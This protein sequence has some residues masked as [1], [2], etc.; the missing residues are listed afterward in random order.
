VSLPTPS[1]QELSGNISDQIGASLEQTV[2]ILPKAFI[3]VLAKVLAGLVVILWK[4]CGFIFLQLFVAYATDKETTING[5]IVR[6]LVELGRRSGI[7]DPEPAI[8]AQHKISVTVTVQ[9]GKLASGTALLF[10]AANIIYETV[11][12]VA[13]DASTVT[14]N[15]RAVSDQSGGDGSGSIGNRQNGDVL[16]FANPPPNVVSKATVVG[17]EVAGTD[18]ETTDA[19]RARLLTKTQGKPQGGCYADYVDWALEVPGI[20]NVY[21]YASP[22]PGEVDIYVEADQASSGSADGIATPAQITAVFNA[23]QFIDSSGL[24]SRRP[25]GA[26]I[27]V[28]PITRTAVLVTVAGFDPDVQATREALKAGVDEFLRTREPYIEGLS[29]L[30]RRDRVTDSAIGGVVQTIVD[31]NGASVTKVTASPGPAFTLGPGQKAKLDHINY[32]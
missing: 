5:K 30:P 23:L 1:T 7:G 25:V 16:E 11:A 17:Q 14:V 20:I 21:P 26:A 9:T 24:A 22:R 19:Y 12:E 8:Q 15:V 4:Y 31:A 3:N 27:N 18:A 13:L 32:A 2:P 10:P 29:T 6:P 28:Y